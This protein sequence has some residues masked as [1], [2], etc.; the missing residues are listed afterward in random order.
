MRD[1]VKYIFD[2][3]RKTSDIWVITQVTKVYRPVPISP[4]RRNPVIGDDEQSS[5]TKNVSNKSLFVFE[6]KIIEN[7]VK[8][9][10][11]L[12]S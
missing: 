4:V 2:F 10:C 8:I 9:C 11:T 5:Y 12:M 7:L 1:F 3:A 6:I